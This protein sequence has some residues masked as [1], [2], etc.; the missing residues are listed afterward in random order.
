MQG[1]PDTTSA[2]LMGQNSPTQEVDLLVFGAGAAGMTVALTAAFERL[3]VLLCEKTDMVGG[4][5]STSAGTIWVPGTSQSIR[6]GTPDSAEDAARFLDSV[7]GDRKGANLRAVFLRSGPEAIDELEEKSEVRFVA[8]KA[9]PDYLGNHPGAA[10]G[11][12]ALGP[13]P[14]DGRLL[15]ADFKRVRPPRPEFLG[16]G[17]MMVG[18]DELEPLLKPFA[19]IAHLR[20]AIRVVLP[21]LRDRLSYRRGT[22]LLMGNALVARLLYSLRRYQVPI[23]F[24]SSLKRL[25]VKDGAV[26][27]AVIDTPEG[28]RVIQARCGVVIATGGIAW[29]KELR[30]KVYPAPTRE[31]S[32]APVTNT[33]D[34]VSAAIA[35]GAAL[36]NTQNS[37]GLWMPCSFMKNPDG[38]ETVW[39]HIILDRAKPGLIAVNK[40]GRRFVNESDSYHDFSMGMLRDSDQGPSIPAWLV[41]DASFL[42]DYGLGLVLP[43]RRSLR[44]F[45]RSGYLIEAASLHELAQK[46][47]VDAAR[48][49]RTV[50]NHN[51]YAKTGNDEEFGRGTSPMN[52]FNGDTTN[53]P[54]PCMRPIGTGPFYAVEVWP[55]D[56]ASSAGV[57]GDEFG[58]ALDE[59]NKPISGLYVCGNDMASIFRGTY[60]GPGTTLGPAIVFAWRIAKHAAGRLS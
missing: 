43:G 41:C 39:P 4:T 31:F 5:T 49:E 17:G 1:R 19:S 27:G 55:A 34:G 56:L 30:A 21:Y 10:Y 35:I 42:R 53:K 25:I 44:R 36:D 2:E 24:E 40:H 9:H 26:N 37:A 33:G 3:D 8:A 48:L 59:Y 15:G 50:A 52:R 11:G 47:G 45:I 16:L 12:R 13:L 60:P 28:E 38:T 54:N 23:R 20:T 46:I 29:N 22:R 7:V 18:R 58:R 14:F 51:R 6:D 32:L 57:K